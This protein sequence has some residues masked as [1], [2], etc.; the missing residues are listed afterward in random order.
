MTAPSASTSLFVVT[1]CPDQEFDPKSIND[2]MTMISQ[3]PKPL[4]L[5]CF[6]KNLKRPLSINATSSKMSVQPAVSA[7]DP[8]IFI[9]KG[10]LVMS[11]VTAGEGSLILEFS[12]WKSDVR[13]IKGEIEIPVVSNFKPVDAFTRTITD[14]RTTCSGCHTGEQTESIYNG[15][16]MYSSRTLKPTTSTKVTLPELQAQYYLCQS[17]SSKGRRCA[18]YSAL[19]SKGQVSDIDF[20]ADT[21]TLLSGF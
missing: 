21:P 16:Q 14:N 4:E 20:P 17:Q 11:F 10:N 19:F 9:F 18:I 5:E 2:L 12:E 3:L 7:Q 13:S 1:N 8:R 6:L 15:I